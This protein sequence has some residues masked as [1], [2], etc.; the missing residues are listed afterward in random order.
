MNAQ[1][2]DDNVAVSVGGEEDTL[3]RSEEETDASESSAKGEEF[4]SEA[5]DGADGEEEAELSEQKDV[6]GPLPT[7]N[8]MKS[9]PK[10]KSADMSASTKGKGS[11]LLPAFLSLPS[12]QASPP[13]SPPMAL[14]ASE[15]TLTPIMPGIVKDEN[16]QSLS[17][18][19]TSSSASSSGEAPSLATVAVNAASAVASAAAAAV[20]SALNRSGLNQ[21]VQADIINC[22]WVAV[23]MF[24]KGVG[25]LYL[26]FFF[27]CQLDFD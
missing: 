17:S 14:G 9:R 6:V 5:E 8:D 7:P 10:S 11:T 16:D 12:P 15:L 2:K 27:H 24:L 26:S 19:S 23:W 21:S 3:P 22:R 4:A 13:P 18:S 20:V 25:S 1:E